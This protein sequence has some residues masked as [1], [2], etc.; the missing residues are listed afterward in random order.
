MTFMRGYTEL[1]D[2]ARGAVKSDG[3]LLSF[4]DQLRRFAYEQMPSGDMFVVA[5]SSKDA[6][7]AEMADLPIVMKQSTVRKITVS[8]ELTLAD[9]R[10]LPE[11]LR[12]YPLALDS[13]SEIDSMLLVTDAE[14]AL[15]QTVLIA[16]H[17]EREFR[18]LV[19]NEIA[20]IYGKR[21]LAY[22]IENTVAAGKEVHVNERTGGW[23]QHTGLP[24]PERTAD[25]LLSKIIHQKDNSCNSPASLG[26]EARDMAAARAAGDGTCTR[27]DRR[28]PG[29]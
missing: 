1:K 14:D 22:L 5:A 4:D 29:R 26:G 13:L 7:I 18:Q 23:L 6:G 17:A 21:N 28:E 10:R 25:H 15:G 27:A 19:V 3:T 2:I 8:H 9:L 11:W 24:L 16:L 20:S 12:T